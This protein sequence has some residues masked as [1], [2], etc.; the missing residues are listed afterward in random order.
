MFEDFVGLVRRLSGTQDEFV[1]LHA[2]V[3]GGSEKRFLTEAVD[4]TFVSSIGRQVSE[5]EDGIARYTG[6][7]YAI[8]TVNGTAAIHA[9]LHASGVALGQEVI[10]Q[11]LSFVATCNAIHYCGAKPVFV[12]VNRHTLGMCPDSLRRFLASRT[13]S[14]SGDVINQATGRRIVACVPVHTYGHPC[15]ISEI[16]EICAEYQLCVIED[17]AESLGSFY[18][19]LHTGTIGDMGVLSF[20]GNKIITTGGG[21]MILIDQ[22][23]MA[24]RLRHLTTTA[25][26]AHPWK[27]DHD[28]VGFN[29]RM[30]NLNAALGL[31]QLEQLESFIV[32]K[33]ALR[34]VYEDFF[35][36]HG[37]H[38]VSEPTNC[39]SNYWLH[40]IIFDD[41]E[42]RDVFLKYTNAR[43]VMTRPAW[44]PLH[45]LPMYADC[46]RYETAA[47]D[48]LAD[49]IVNIP[50]SA[51]L[52]ISQE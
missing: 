29:Y 50:S 2:P 24:R 9:A 28:E 49:R 15:D 38:Y 45:T 7:K 12:D 41:I 48:F 14:S 18:D 44:Q 46:D 16:R 35:E 6:S 1:P 30:P 43:G 19:G 11:P 31:G 40:T 33:R 17:A 27:Y 20:N 5:F 34:S 26:I 51:N 25:K 8:A 52:Q 3:F 4:S 39:R 10:T 42:T 36:A 13:V 47:A 22:E 37:V 21:G 23:D 32:K